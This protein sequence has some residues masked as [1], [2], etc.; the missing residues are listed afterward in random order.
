[1]LKMLVKNALDSSAHF[2][3][4]RKVPAFSAAMG[5]AQFLFTPSVQRKPG[6]EWR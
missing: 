3:K 4:K 2:A 6:V 5:I 1:M